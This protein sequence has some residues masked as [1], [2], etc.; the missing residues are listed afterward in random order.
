[1]DYS[2]VIIGAGPSG[3]SAG[4]KLSLLGVKDFLIIDMGKDVKERDRY[5]ESD[6]ICGVG[7][8][9]LFSDGKFSFFPSATKLWDL[10]NSKLLDEAL[11]YVLSLTKIN[12]KDISI[13]SLTS[14]PSPTSTPTVE[15]TKSTEKWTLKD[16]P[17]LYISLEARQ[18]I[19]STLCAKIS[20]KFLLGVKVINITKKISDD[21]IYEL[22]LLEN[23]IE[24][25]INT[26]KI[27]IAGGR[28]QSLNKMKLFEYQFMRFEYGVRIIT[29]HKNKYFQERKTIDPKY[30]YKC[31]EE[32]VEYRT[33]CC[34]HRGE[35]V[36]TNF[37][38]DIKSFSGRADCSPTDLS[39]TGFNVRISDKILA[40]MIQSTMFSTGNRSQVFKDL[41]LKEVLEGKIN[42]NRYFGVTGAKLLVDG[43]RLFVEKFPEL[44]EAKISGPT[45]EGIGS[46]ISTD[47]NSKVINENIWVI[48][49]ASGKYRGLTAGL[50]SGFCIPDILKIDPS[51]I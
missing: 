27:I 16:Y 29:D 51:S 48:G 22:V 38:G 20:D 25:K 28:M 40:E 33:F 23:G 45:I 37:C 1:M 9:G 39:N 30:K 26:K 43:L 18:E 10:F 11:G 15:E 4:Y 12:K 49:D 35:I 32:L 3:L 24:K 13:D 5:N 19:I 44:L 17:S 21:N 14:I 41:S 2:V 50:I 42:L 46:Y 7:G 31:S 36:C 8:A 47:D 34:C 6:S